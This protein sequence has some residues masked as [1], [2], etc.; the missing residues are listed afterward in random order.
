MENSDRR[1]GEGTT[2]VWDNKE[3]WKERRKAR[4]P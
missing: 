4:A 2:K 1:G 3:E